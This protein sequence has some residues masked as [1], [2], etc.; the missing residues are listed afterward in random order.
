MKVSKFGGS[1]LADAKQF[2]KV[3]DIIKADNSRKIVVV[4]APGKRFK[5]DVKVTDLLINCAKT[6]YQ[7]G[8]SD[9]DLELVI[10]RY[11]EIA[12]EL[13]LDSGIIDVIR[14][15][16]NQRLANTSITEGQYIDSL[17]ASGEDNCA[18]LMAEHL[19][20]QGLE[21]NYISPKEAGLF[22]SNDYGNA[23]VLQQSY[24]NLA[25]LSEN[26]G[27]VVFP[28][29]FG[30]TPEG[31]LV[32]F[33]RGG[34]DI[35]GSILAAAVK[36]DLYE[37]FTDVDCV[38]SVNPSLVA[39]PKAIYELTYREMREL[40]YGG[41][42]V[43]H[44]EALLPAYKEKIPVKIKNTNNPDCKGTLIVADR[45]PENGP[46]VGIASD[47]G[48][49]SIY[50][51]KY[52]MNRE[53]GFGRKLLQI[54]E[55]EGLSY[56]HTPSGI[57]DISV[58]LHE[59]QFDSQTEEKVTN[60]IRTE[61]EVDDIAVKRNI[62]LVMIVGEGMRQSIGVAAKATRAFERANVNLDMINQGSSEVS[63]MFGVNANDA[64]RA[65]QALYKEFFDCN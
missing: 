22:L 8:K 25:K 16:L 35:T 17:K 7:S 36:A 61:L 50:V 40:S 64:D 13:G 33:S 21:A 37:N 26:A 18:K 48:F 24:D 41:F 55:E 43:L 27:I 4:S 12:E 47:T 34:S 14:D 59:E 32:T 15:D 51:S 62:A 2:R 52:L 5:E 23:H 49:C 1:S 31:D 56:E 39:N 11:K 44:A 65:V 19:R 57:D 46:V 38:F 60:R 9:D 54:L 10:S 42:S 3:S 45:S 58:I 30:Y 53:I 29:F 28:G 20:N 63:M 6:H